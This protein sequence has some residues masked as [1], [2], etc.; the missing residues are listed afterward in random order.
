MGRITAIENITLDGVV[1]GPASPEE[2]TRG[3]FTQGGWSPPYGDEVLASYMGVGM[4]DSSAGAAALLFGR[5]TYESFAAFWPHQTDNPFTPVLNAATKYVCSRTLREPLPWEGSVLLSGDAAESV[6]RLKQ[7]S[8]AD[9][10]VL[11][12]GTLVRSLLVAD[13]VDSLVLVVHPLVLGS[14]SRLLDGGLPRQQWSLAEAVPTT[15]GVII[16]A[17]DRAPG[18]R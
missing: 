14:G 5:W 1:Q 3:G 17:Y 13:L 9:L 2:D 18:R 7:E 11:G 16:A 15:T 8:A 6:A 10:T 12:S 4:A